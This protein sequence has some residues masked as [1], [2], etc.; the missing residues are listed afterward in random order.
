ME[1]P[2]GELESA[3]LVDFDN[4]FSGEVDQAQVAQAIDDMIRRTLASWPATRRIDIRMY[5]GWLDEGLLTKRAS[6]LETALALATAF[7]ISHPTQSGILR[8]SVRLATRL[9]ALP[10]FEWGH[11]LRT[12]T[13]LPRVG[14]AEEPFPARCAHRT[15]DCPVKAVQT[16]ARRP[17]RAC[18]ASGCTVTNQAAFRVREQKMVDVMLACDTIALSAKHNVLVLSS[19]LD[20]LPAIAMGAARDGA[21]ISLIRDGRRTADLYGQDLERFGV[22]VDDWA[23]G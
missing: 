7:P 2:E 4:F 12:R 21:R 9:A 17:G 3:V 11:T 23:V 1:D 20:I 15:R 8:G 13:G 16:F 14:L 5:G 22:A 6:E 10:D 19:D 18:R